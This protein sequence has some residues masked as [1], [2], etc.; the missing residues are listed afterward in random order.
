MKGTFFSRPL[1][2]SIETEKESW[3]QGESIK[4][5]L[6]VKNHGADAVNLNDAG[7]ALAFADIKKVHTKAEGALKLESREAFSDVSL[8]ANEAR[9][10]PFNLSLPANCPVTDKKASYFLTYGKDSSENHLMLK[11]EPKALYGKVIGLL[12][13]FHRFKLKEY[14]SA[15]KGVEYKLIPPTSRDMANL[16]SLNLIFSMNGD[17]LQMDYDFQVRKLDTQA[18]TTK[19]N[20]EAVKIQKVLTPREYSLGKEMINQD[21]LLKSLEAAIAEVKLKSVF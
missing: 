7:A 21:T 16:E 20:K 5:I 11:I 6:R 17:N 1:E 12:D 10:I 4:G 18:P 14:K 2:W 9:E 13:T 8:S 19:V 15:K 3:T